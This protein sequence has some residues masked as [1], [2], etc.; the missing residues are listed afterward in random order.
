MTVGASA[1]GTFAL[2]GDVSVS[3]LGYGAMRITGPGIMGEPRDTDEARRVLLRTVELG[4][5]FI[6]TAHAYGPLVSERLIGETL[7]PYQDDVVIATKGGLHR[8]GAWLA[9][10]S[11]ATLRAELEQ[12]LQLLRV[13]TIDLYQLH[14]VD[15]RVP[16]SESVG[17]LAQ[18]QREGL[19]TMIGLSNV[20]VDE[21]RAAQ[22]EAQIVSVQNRFSVGDR[23]SVLDVCEREGLA[24]IPW[25]PL[26]AGAV[27]SERR[28]RDVAARLGATTFQ[29]ALAWLLRRSPN[30]L[31]IPG[32]S[33][34]PHLEENVA[35]AALALSDDDFNALSH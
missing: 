16:V 3:R 5:T 10:G 22:G 4:V 11:P 8:N 32:T 17:A 14:T 9:D 35:A 27:E 13:E 31:P 15:P 30:M 29:V 18:M 24:F 19:I 6:D 1:A 7:A 12:S 26:R 23:E 25:Y 21:L 33:T 20:D 34:V 28:L 2:G